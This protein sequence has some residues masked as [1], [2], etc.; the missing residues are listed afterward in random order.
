M[1]KQ[2]LWSLVVV[3]SLLLLGCSEVE[4]EHAE[5]MTSTVE[6]PHSIISTMY[7]PECY[8]VYVERSGDEQD[9]LTAISEL[10]ELL[11]ER[12]VAPA[13]P[14]FVLYTGDSYRVGV[15]VDEAVEP[16]DELRVE[17]LP[18]RLVAYLETLGAY[19]ED[20]ITEHEQLLAWVQLSGFQAEEAVRDYYLNWDTEQSPEYLMA[21]VTVWISLPPE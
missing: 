4:E 8:L 19:G 5:V 20:R 12:E 13:G 1:I 15:A 7:L 14:P 11:G 17:K 9:S 10:E 18:R 16:W 2:V 3:G 6:E 21:E